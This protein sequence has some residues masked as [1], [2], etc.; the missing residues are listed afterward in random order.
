MNVSGTMRSVNHV[1][2]GMLAGH[3]FGGWAAVLS[4]PEK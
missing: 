2:A 3:E 1:L 4:S